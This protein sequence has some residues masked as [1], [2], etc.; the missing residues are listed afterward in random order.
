MKKFFLA[1]VAVILLG[2]VSHDAF[3]AATAGRAITSR[4]PPGQMFVAGKGCVTDKNAMNGVTGGTSG[5]DLA[6]IYGADAGAA[7]HAVNTR[8]PPGQTFI[9]GKGC[10][11]SAG[12]ASKTAASSP[13]IMEPLNVP[14]A[15]LAARAINSRCPPGQ[16]FVA[17]KGCVTDKNAAAS[18]TNV[19]MIDT[20]GLNAATAVESR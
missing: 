7:Y 1:L 19:P 11:L 10:A 5:G 9:V 18:V 16:K 17:G 3:A 4:C 8:C 14:D 2:V 12:S 6:P 15:A 13:A 20:P